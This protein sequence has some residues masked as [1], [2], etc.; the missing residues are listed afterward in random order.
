MNLDLSLQL[1]VFRVAAAVLLFTVQ[2][3]AIAA[4]TVLLGDRGPRY[5][6]RLTLSPAAHVDLVGL[7]ALVLSG[8]GWGRSVA[9]DGREL[10]PGRWALV[11]VALTG[12]LVLLVAAPILLL[13]VPP[14]LELLPFSAGLGAAAFLRLAAETAVWNGLLALVPVPPLAAGLMLTGAGITIGPKLRALLVALVFAVLVT[15][16]VRPA[17]AP[18]QQIVA[19]FLLPDWARR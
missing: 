5:D 11:L 14:A 8:L 17:L 15:G 12:G 9:V 4:V 1:V 6:G 3:L 2:G 13:L 16:V 7:L 18:A 10:R 19:P